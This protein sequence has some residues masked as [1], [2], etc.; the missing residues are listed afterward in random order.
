MRKKE[1][2]TQEELSKKSGVTVRTIRAYEEK[3]REIDKAA[4]SILVNL[5]FALECDISDILESETAIK[6]YKIVKRF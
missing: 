1:N 4:M 5:C 2:I 3:S 6:K